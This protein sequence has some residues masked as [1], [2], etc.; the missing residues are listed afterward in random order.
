MMRHCALMLHAL[1]TIMEL[2]F[3]NLSRGYG[4]GDACMENILVDEKT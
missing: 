3:V 4:G 2:M 1:N